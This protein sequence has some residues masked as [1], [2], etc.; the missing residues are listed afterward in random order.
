MD[1]ILGIIIGIVGL[2]YLH[3]YLK[4]DFINSIEHKASHQQK[5]TTVQSSAKKMVA[6]KKAHSNTEDIVASKSG[7]KPDNFKRLDG[8]GPKIAKLLENKG[9]LTYQQLSE[10]D[11][12]QLTDLFQKEGVRIRQTD[13]AYWTKQAKLAAEGKW[14][15]IKKLQQKQKS[16]RTGKVAKAA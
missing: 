12:K 10:M 15:D 9:L 7:V 11:V 8:I 16:K 2:W 13:P 3:R 6:V 1:T 4:F 5:P 14:D